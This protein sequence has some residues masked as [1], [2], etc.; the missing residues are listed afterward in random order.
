MESIETYEWDE[1][2]R[3]GNISKHGVD[4]VAAVQ[5]FRDPLLRIEADGREEYDEVRYRATGLIS[6]RVLVVVYTER[7]ETVRIISAR[8]ATP[9]ERRQYHEGSD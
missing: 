2:K 1:S 9:H 7:D 8:R 4:F 3:R 5:I 6:G